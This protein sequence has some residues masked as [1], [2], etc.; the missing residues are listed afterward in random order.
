MM[1][2]KTSEI[3]LTEV[4]FELILQICN[5]F[6]VFIDMSIVKEDAGHGPRIV[7]RRSSCLD[8]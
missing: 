1:V 4:G 5:V 8:R 6:D 2:V 7:H 3:F